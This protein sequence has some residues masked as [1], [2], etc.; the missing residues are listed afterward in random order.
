MRRINQ[1]FFKSYTALDKL[2]SERFGTQ[3]GVTDYIEEMKNIYDPY[4]YMGTDPVP[5]WTTDY[6]MLKHLRH[7][8]N[9][10]AHE[11]GA[12]EADLIENKDIDWIEAFYKRLLQG[13][14]PLTRYEAMRRKVFKVRTDYKK[15]PVQTERS[16]IDD[17]DYKEKARSACQFAIAVV[18]IAAA[19][20]LW[21]T[22]K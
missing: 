16:Y 17:T 11:A 14:D 8:R 15:R 7:V 4:V 9:Q 10:L 20:L 3:R 5:G 1:E 12:F 18:I 2:C 22:L 19:V 21:L 6:R 13:A